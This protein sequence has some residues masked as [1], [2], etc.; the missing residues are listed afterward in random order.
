MVPPVVAIL[1][2]LRVD[3]RRRSSFMGALPLQVG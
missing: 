1:P 3:S 2:H